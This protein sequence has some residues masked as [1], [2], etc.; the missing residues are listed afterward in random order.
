MSG[1]VIYINRK[2]CA[3]FALLSMWWPSQP[4]TV[5]YVYIIHLKLAGARS[6][7][8]AP[9]SVFSQASLPL[10]VPHREALSVIHPPHRSG[11]VTAPGKS[12]RPMPGK[13]A[14]ASSRVLYES[15]SLCTIRGFMENRGTE[16]HHSPVNGRWRHGPFLV[17]GSVPDIN[18]LVMNHG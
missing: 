12:S 1:P 4:A 5:R 18:Q 10:A 2:Y 14:S 3:D 17:P 7:D 6:Q 8:W 11:T 13:P 15:F 9:V 16:S